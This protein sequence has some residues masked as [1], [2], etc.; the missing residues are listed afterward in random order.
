VIIENRLV[1]HGYA[2]LLLCAYHSDELS[3]NRAVAEQPGFVRVSSLWGFEHG[4][5]WMHLSA[6]TLTGEQRVDTALQE[7]A[8]RSIFDQLFPGLRNKMWEGKVNDDYNNDPD[9]MEQMNLWVVQAQG[10]DL[11]RIWRDLFSSEADGPQGGD[12]TTFDY[13]PSAWGVVLHM[14]EDLIALGVADNGILQECQAAWDTMAKRW[15]P[16]NY[17]FASEVVPRPV[18][19][20][21]VARLEA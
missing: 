21:P 16:S 4:E 9:A 14:A 2:Q 8:M 10:P 20:S 5:V 19:V 18:V 13:W 3:I 12:D 17:D 15:D 6:A 11:L 1:Q 7:M